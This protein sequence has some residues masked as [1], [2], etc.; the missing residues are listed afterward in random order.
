MSPL[1]NVS[2]RAATGLPR[3]P[4]RPL[5]AVL[6]SS[7]KTQYTL[8]CLSHNLFLYLIHLLNTL[9]Y[10]TNPLH[11]LPPSPASTEPHLAPPTNSL[12]LTD[13]DQLLDYYSLLPG[14][15]LILGDMNVHNDNPDSN[16]T[17]HICHSLSNHNMTQHI[18]GP[19]IKQDTH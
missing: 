15:L 7:T 16:E 9:H 12:F 19:T 2:L 6:P 17:K 10:L 8:F 14:N 11:T 13:F 3:S 5:V 18:S 4:V 1:K